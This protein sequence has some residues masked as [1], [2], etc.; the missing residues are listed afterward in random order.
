MSINPHHR[1]FDPIDGTKIK[2]SEQRKF[3]STV[4]KTLVLSLILLRVL[5]FAPQSDAKET[6]PEQRVLRVTLNN[7]LRVVLV[8]NALAPVVTT[9]MNYL[10]GSVE[11]PRGFP[12]TAHAQEHMMFRGSPGLSADQLAGII[13]AMGGKFNADTQQTVT[14]Y[15]LT[16]PSADLDTA[17]HIEA[18]RMRGVLDSE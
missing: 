10:V 18:I 2:Q 5:A 1:V 7:G 6:G 16:V 3:L 12:G 11:A 8:R 13:A 14:Q 4:S 17:L 9:M 15:F